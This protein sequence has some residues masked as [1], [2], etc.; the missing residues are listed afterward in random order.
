M[1]IGLV[2]NDSIAVNKTEQWMCPGA[3]EVSI[4]YGEFTYMDL[5]FTGS[6][7]KQVDVSY[8]E[9]IVLDMMNLTDTASIYSQYR[10]CC[11]PLSF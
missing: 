9:A 5:N 7:Q 11:I 1:K 2:Y 4:R 10:L 8:L 6:S 3:F